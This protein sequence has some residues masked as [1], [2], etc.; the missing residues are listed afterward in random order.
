MPVRR[1][2]SP[3]RRF[4][5]IVIGLGLFALVVHAVFGERGY[6]GLRSQ[7]GVYERLKQE[8]RTLE[9]ENQQ[10]KEEIKALKSDPRAVERVA[11]EELKMAKPGEVVITLPEKKHHPP[12]AKPQPNSNK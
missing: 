11:R 6:L 5:L 10:L 12:E 1:K 7:R 4:L 8:V 9:E 3:W 2:P